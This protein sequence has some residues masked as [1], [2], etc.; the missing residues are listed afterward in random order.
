MN[1]WMNFIYVSWGFSIAANWGLLNN[2]AIII[3]YKIKAIILKYKNEKNTI[4]VKKDS[5]VKKNTFDTCIHFSH[6]FDAVS[7]LCSIKSFLDC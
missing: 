5:G 4:K 2:K 6:R 7:I 3:I 1:E